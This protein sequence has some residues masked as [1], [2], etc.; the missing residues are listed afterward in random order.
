MDN[1]AAEAARAAAAAVSSGRRGI[2]AVAAAASDV[3]RNT[4]KY[5][6]SVESIYRCAKPHTLSVNYFP[7]SFEA[8]LAFF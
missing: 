8:H 6:D 7:D 4:T 2:G 3:R 1:E 5:A